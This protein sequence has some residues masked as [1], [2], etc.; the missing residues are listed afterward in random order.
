MT[1][2]SCEWAGDIDDL[3]AFVI[4]KNLRRRH[5]DESQRAAMVAAKLAN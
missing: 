4:S 1:V 2:F 5:L 3:A